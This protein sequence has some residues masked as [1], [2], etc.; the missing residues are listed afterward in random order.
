MLDC[1]S[2]REVQ[3][4][5]FAL[6]RGPDGV[7]AAMETV[8]LSEPELCRMVDGD[9]RLSALGRVGI[10]AD[11]YFLR[12]RDVLRDTFPKLAIAMGE[13]GFS[14][15]VTDYLEA[16]LSRHPSLRQLGNH[17]PSFLQPQ[18][19]TLR[20][21]SP[22]LPAWAADLASLEWHRYDVFDAAD[23]S[24]LSI[25]QLRALP[26]DRFAEM[27]VRLAPSC[28]LF[29]P[30]HPVQDVWRALKTG[31]PV[32]EPAATPTQLLV[33]RQG[34]AV[35]HRALEPIEAAALALAENG[36]RFA[37]VCELVAERL[38]RSEAAAQAAFTLLARWAT[39]SLL[40]A[41]PGIPAHTQ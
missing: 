24:L 32:D 41:P 39:D 36:S 2:L 40:V 9:A 5:L 31:A 23:T 26:A 21:R 38:P 10:Y 37:L 15:L 34:T 3:R 27:P 35:Y 18:A 1:P 29:R 20:P 11:M 33:W 7:E 28:R 6:F 19:T 25:D 12:L 4:R 16:H 17:L 13:D 14:A 30:R 8:G 22:A